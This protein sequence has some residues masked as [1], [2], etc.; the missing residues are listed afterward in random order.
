M[1]KGTSSW[2]ALPAIVWIGE[3]LP[4]AFAAKTRIEFEDGL[5]TKM[6]PLRRLTAIPWANELAGGG[7][8]LNPV[9]DPAITRTGATLPVAPPA[10]SLIDCVSK[11]KT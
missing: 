10:N 11:S 9:L 4:L 2:V 5:A 1:F 8:L 3:M 6:S 7:K